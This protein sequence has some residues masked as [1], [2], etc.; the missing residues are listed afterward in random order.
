MSEVLARLRRANHGPARPFMGV[1]RSRRLRARNDAID[2][3]RTLEPVDR[4][5]NPSI[6]PLLISRELGILRCVLSDGYRMQFDQQNRRE[7]VTLLGG[8]VVAWPLAARG[9]QGERMRRLGVLMS[10]AESDTEGQARM[11]AFRGQFQKL[12]WTEGRTIQIDIRWQTP[13]PESLHRFAKELVAL[14]PDVIL[15]ENTPS[16]AALLQQ[17]RTIPIVVAVVSDPVGSGFVAS[18][19]RPGGNV[20]GFLKVEGSLGGKWMELLKEIA[21]RVAR[22]AFLYNSTT[23]PFSE[24][25]L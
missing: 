4:F 6:T 7:V 14:Q 12:G 16:T 9:Q 20:T 21:P 23:A 3:T 8:A 24:F 10:Y 22:V 2:P 1:K 5:Q 25:Y 15:S 11:A 18:L 19:A 17:T 13:D